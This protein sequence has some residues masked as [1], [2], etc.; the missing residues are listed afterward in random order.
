MERLIR[1][2]YVWVIVLVLVFCADL[3]FRRSAANAKEDK[4]DETVEE[5]QG[6]ETTTGD[7]DVVPDDSSVPKQEEKVVVTATNSPVIVPAK[8]PIM[9]SDDDDDDEGNN[10]KIATAPVLFEKSFAKDATPSSFSGTTP[11]VTPASNHLPVYH[12]PVPGC[13][14]EMM[15]SKRHNPPLTARGTVDDKQ[16][17]SKAFQNQSYKFRHHFQNKHPEIGESEWPTGFAYV[18]ASKRKA[19]AGSD[20]KSKAKKARGQ[21][22]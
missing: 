15:F 17:W 3:F 22:V 5:T 16:R 12:C 18:R 8:E 21:R 6:E 2:G 4:P 14:F 10:N 9:D 13:T 7:V 20:T 1:V 19:A 11:A